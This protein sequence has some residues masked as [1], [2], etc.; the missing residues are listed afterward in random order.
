M[1]NTLTG[2]LRWLLALLLGTIALLLPNL[3]LLPHTS[4]LDAVKARDF[5]QVFTRNTPTTFYEGRQGPTGFEYELSRRFADYLGVSLAV[6]HNHNIASVL[7]GVRTGQADLGAAGLALDPSAFGVRFSRPIMTMQPLVVY[8][9]GQPPITS[10]DDLLDRNIG[11]IANSGADLALRDAQRDHPGLS[12]KQT[13]D[14]E[15]TDLLRLVNN[16]TLDAAVIYAHQFRLN[17]LFFP[18]VENGFTLGNTLTLAWAFPD[19]GDFALLDEANAFIDTLRAN[20][21]LTAL[22]EQYFGHDDYL[23]YVGARH[24]IRQARQRLPDYI[25]TFKA[26]AAESGFDWKLLAA[27][28]Y[29]E[30]HWDPDAVSPTGVRGLMMLTTPTANHMGVDDRTDAEQSI[31]GGARYLASVKSRL[32]ESIP[33]PDRTWVALAAYNIGLGHLFDARHVV[34]L[35]GGNPD[36]WQ[37]IRTALPLLQ[38]RKWYRQVRHGFV[39]GNIAVFY[40]RNI[41]RYYEILNYIYRSQQQFYPLNELSRDPESTDDAFDTVP[42]VL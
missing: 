27:V 12:W 6:D 36:R 37:D 8:R 5:L 41:R 32:P 22:I 34:K 10:L 31:N 40:V 20:G 21:T 3:A 16:G 33:E 39:Q 9:R 13:S 17:R 30:S 7:D 35:R 26:A 23:E 19:N 28:G 4:S 14:L 38:E 15:A 29:Q 18:G 24:F 42:P 1:L 11:V 2:R 25:D